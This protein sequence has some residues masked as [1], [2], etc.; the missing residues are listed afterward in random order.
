MP[1]EWKPPLRVQV[2][3]AGFLLVLAI[4]AFRPSCD[5]HKNLQDRLD[6]FL[7][8]TGLWQGRWALF[9]PEVD[10]VNLRLSAQIMFDDGT[11][12][13]WRSPEWEKLSPLQRFRLARHLN[14]W[15]NVLKQGKEPAWDGLCAYLARTVP[16]PLGH[17]ASVQRVQLSL[18]G[19]LIPP[20]EKGELVPARPYAAFDPP[21]VIHVWRP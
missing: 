15:N 17:A 3:L 5:L 9:G 10:R 14:Y 4:D 12:A 11:V 6:F 1:E 21:D 18:R 2:F 8:V 16:H 20:L 7:D 13:T 19:A